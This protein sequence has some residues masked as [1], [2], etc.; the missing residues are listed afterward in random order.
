V[1][2]AFTNNESVNGAPTTRPPPVEARDHKLGAEQAKLTL[3]EYGDFG[4]PFCFAA[5]RPVSSLLARYET[6]RLVWRHFPDPDLHPG[7]D[8]A[9]ELS[10][11]ATLR[12][13]FW[14]AHD[15][16]LAGRRAFSQGD[17]LSVAAELGLDGAVVERSLAERTSR[18]RVL[19]DVRG[20]KSAGVHGTPTFFLGGERVDCHWRQLAQL[21]TAM[22]AASL[23]TS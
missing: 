12:G 2:A 13:R 14:D 1:Q 17:L 22:L 16:L 6:L 23:P 3:I 7:A 15:V 5:K 11:L 4:C 20:G 21:V 19:G 10:E 9:A 8:L 18:E